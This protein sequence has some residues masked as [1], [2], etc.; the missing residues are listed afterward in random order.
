MTTS[1]MQA[2]CS[3]AESTGICTLGVGFDFSQGHYPR[4]KKCVL[5]EPGAS[6]TFSD[7]VLDGQ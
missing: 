5:C 7:D 4:L 2:S 3:N 6:A 1:G